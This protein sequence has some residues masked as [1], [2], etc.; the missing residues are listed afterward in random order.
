MKKVEDQMGSWYQVKARGLLGPEVGDTKNITILNR[1]LE[2]KKEGIEHRADKKHV[3]KI[4]ED[5]GMKGDSK[6]STVPQAKKTMEERTM[7][8]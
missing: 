7:R 3:K 5:L 2:W 8:S 6:V 1:S 4:M